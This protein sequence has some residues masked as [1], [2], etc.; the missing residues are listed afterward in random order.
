MHF[1]K[2]NIDKMDIK[3]PLLKQSDGKPSVSFTMA[4]VGFNV[5]LLWLLLSIFEF[6]GPV[7]VRAFSSSDAMAF[8]TP[9]LMQYFGRRWVDAKN[10]PSNETSDQKPTGDA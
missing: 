4:F 6:S 2:G 1:L 9:L 5:V 7:K 8:L 10:S 3:V